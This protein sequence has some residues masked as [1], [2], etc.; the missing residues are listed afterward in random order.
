MN[1]TA[2]FPT[3]ADIARFLREEREAGRDPGKREVARAFGVSAGG[4]IWL[5]KILK[6]IEAEGDAAPRAGVAPD[7]DASRLPASC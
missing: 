6:E 3:R 5:K 1:R 4:K 2:P 7:E